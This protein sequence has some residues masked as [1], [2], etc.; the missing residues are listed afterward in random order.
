MAKSRCSG[1]TWVRPS[2]T[3]V[4]PISIRPDERRSMPASERSS[5][6]FPDPEGPRRTM[7]VPAST[8]N[9][10]PR[11]AWCPPGYTLDTLST[12][13]RSATEGRPDAAPASRREEP[14]GQEHERHDAQRDRDA[15]HR[16]RE[17]EPE[18]V[19]RDVEVDRDRER[20][21]AGRVEQL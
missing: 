14:V 10:G 16:L 15:D 1:G 21:R 18:V 11:S 3:I 12:T 6:V 2:A 9:V 20:G 5:V 7:K 17:P 4:E 8:V 13:R 19:P